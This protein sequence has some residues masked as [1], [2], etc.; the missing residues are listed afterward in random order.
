MTKK[1]LKKTERRDRI[2]KSKKPISAWHDIDDTY[3]EW[4]K[5]L[6]RRGLYEYN[7]KYI[8]DGESWSDYLSFQQDDTF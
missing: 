1:T 8:L 4:E 3:G 6:K 5:Y 7:N 2:K